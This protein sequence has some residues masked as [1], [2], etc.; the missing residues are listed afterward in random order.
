VVVLYN[1]IWYSLPD[2]RMDLG[3]IFLKK[4]NPCSDDFLRIP[5]MH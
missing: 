5:Q 2:T 4:S 1:F 3:N